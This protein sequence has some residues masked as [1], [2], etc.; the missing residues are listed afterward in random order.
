MRA[1]AMIVHIKPASSNR[2]HYAS[3]SLV[4]YSVC[5]VLLSCLKHGFLDIFGDLLWFSVF[6]VV[7]I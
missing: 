6:D 3:G 2:R 1:S 4:F 7:N 5:L